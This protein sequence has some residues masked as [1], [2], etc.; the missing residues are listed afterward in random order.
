GDFSA[1]LGKKLSNGET[2]EVK[3]KDA[4]GNLSDAATTTVPD[5][6][7]PAAPTGLAADNSGTNTVISGKAEPNSKVVIDGKEYPVNAAGDFSADLGKKLSNGETVEVKAKDASGNLSDAATTTVP[8]TTAPAAPTLIEDSADHK[9]LAREADTIKGTAGR[10]ATKAVLFDQ[11]G[12]QIEEVDINDGSFQIGSAALPDGT[13]QVKVKDAAGNLSDATSITIDKSVPTGKPEVTIVGDGNDADTV[14]D[15]GELGVGADGQLNPVTV[16]VSLAGMQNVKPG[17]KLSGVILLGRTPSY[18][19]GDKSGYSLTENDITNGKVSFTV[20]VT[21]GFTGKLVVQGVK[22]QDAE[23]QSS[24]TADRKEAAL[25]LGADPT[26][27]MSFR[28]DT[29]ISGSDNITTNGELVLAAPQGYTIDRVVVN[30]AEVSLTGNSITLS[31]GTYT[32]GNIQ[33]TVSN[34]TTGRIETVSNT[35]TYVV[36][37]TAPD[38]PRINV[39]SGCDSSISLPENAAIGDVV[40]VNITQPGKQQAIYVKYRKTDSDWEVATFQPADSGLSSAPAVSGNTITIS[41]TVAPAGSTIAAKVTD[42]AGNGSAGKDGGNSFVEAEVPSSDSDNDGYTNEEESRA[43]SDPDQASST[44]KTLAEAAYNKAKATYDAFEARKSEFEKGGFTKEEVSEL[45]KLL[46]PLDGK[47]DKALAAANYVHNNDGKAKLIDDINKLTDTVPEVTNDAD[48]TWS[49]GRDKIF[50]HYKKSTEFAPT[51][52]TEGLTLDD[53]ATKNGGVFVIPASQLV[54]KD[55]DVESGYTPKLKPMKDWVHTL[56]GNTSVGFSEYRVD[57]NGN[58]EIKINA[59]KVKNISQVQNETYE[60]TAEDGTPLTLYVSFE[61]DNKSG[62]SVN[63]FS[64]TVKDDVYPIVG[65]V[66]SNGVT[67]DTQWKDISVALAATGNDLASWK[68]KLEIFDDQNPDSPVWTQ[69][70]GGITSSSKTVSFDASSSF[71]AKNGH[72]YTLKATASSNSEKANTVEERITVDTTPPEVTF[73]LTTDSAGNLKL[74]VELKEPVKYFIYDGK[75]ESDQISFTG[76]QNYSS[77]KDL[78]SMD[79]TFDLGSTPK[80]YIFY[81]QA[82]NAAGVVAP[83]VEVKR[84]GRLTTNMNQNEGP[85]NYMSDGNEAQ[86][87]DTGSDGLK[88]SAG[89][90]I[91]IVAKKSDGDF[92]GGF[93]DGGTGDGYKATLQTYDGNDYIYAFGIGGHTDVITG[94]GND[95]F[96]LRYGLSGWGQTGNIS[97]GAFDGAQRILMG[98]GNDTFKIRGSMIDLHSDYGDNSFALTTAKVDMGIGND[99]I[100]V[101]STIKGDGD[102]GRNYSNYFNLGSGDDVMRVGKNITDTQTSAT[103]S[104]THASNIIDLGAGNDTLIVKG[105]VEQHTLILSEN[106]DNTIS[107]GSGVSLARKSIGGNTAIVL[108]DGNDTL[109]VNTAVNYEDADRESAFYRAYKDSKSDGWYAESATQI[110]KVIE[111]V[112]QP[113]IDLGNGNNTATFGSNVWHAKIITGD[114]QDTITIKGAL[115]QTSLDTGSGNDTVTINEWTLKN[116]SVILGNGDDILYLGGVSQT[117]SYEGTSLIHGGA[118]TDTINITGKSSV[119]TRLEIFGNTGGNNIDVSGVDVLNLNGH[120]TEVIIGTQNVGNPNNE[121]ARNVITIHGNSTDAVKLQ[122]DWREIGSTTGMKQYQYNGITIYID[123]TIQVTTFS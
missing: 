29:G 64:V 110:D 38:A 33:V 23:K 20:P 77:A 41:Q 63:L 31:E 51:H 1:D 19:G 87:N 72:S 61:N 86:R 75:V 3:A 94:G 40:D 57:E 102:A 80:T 69:E 81:D 42:L 30:N 113:K 43:G 17:D 122:S 45:E 92:F 118:G 21:D 11:N 106:G 97:T 101:E 9:L 28:S 109:T 98:D 85:R 48:S 90:N 32:A 88:T 4:S 68:V 62:T 99:T 100:E 55:P 105:S 50:Y 47:K 8:D 123:D 46:F 83:E 27:D 70:K 60:L 120:G 73:N 111:D 22:V 56:P 108:G 14:I 2:V 65:N 71:T 103:P 6:T 18:L 115:S 107:I 116:N 24:A 12:D 79:A 84:L 10:D 7:A 36:D 59:E 35:T 34:T 112:K 91:I 67:D 119:S 39:E 82:G 25:D 54:I 5:T 93:I 117:L 104:T 53:L 26:V 44:P 66:A 74:H 13:Y 76:K 121:L 114:G 89:D 58:L 96:E 78:P 15:R 95:R 16:E 52:N 37:T 49:N